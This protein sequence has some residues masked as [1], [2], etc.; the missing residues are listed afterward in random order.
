VREQLANGPKPRSQIE[1]AV[2]AA[3][4]PE[5]SLIVAADMLG[6]R[7]QKGQ[8]YDDG[9]RVADTLAH[10]HW[11]CKPFPLARARSSRTKVPHGDTR[12]ARARLIQLLLLWSSKWGRPGSFCASNFDQ[13]RKVHIGAG[14]RRPAALPGKP[15]Y[16]A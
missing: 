1:A 5:R 10:T 16:I 8:W 11:A 15:L 4:I 2:K 9:K 3:D 7:T 12:S 13:V 14:F 6:V